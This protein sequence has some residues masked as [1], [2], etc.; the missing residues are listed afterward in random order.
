MLW[1]ENMASTEAESSADISVILPTISGETFSSISKRSSSQ[2][3]VLKPTVVWSLRL[4]PQ[5]TCKK[6]L[7]HNSFR[8][9]ALAAPI[10]FISEP[11]VR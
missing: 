2:S 4:N 7:G 9:F 1:L 5:P 6:T 10:D 11:H 3:A 8:V